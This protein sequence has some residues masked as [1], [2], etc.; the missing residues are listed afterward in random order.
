MIDKSVTVDV[1]KLMHDAAQNPI[2]SYRLRTGMKSRELAERWGTSFATLSRI[3]NGTQ[4]IPDKLL[5][6]ISRDTGAPIA[7]LR[8][9]LVERREELTEMLAEVGVQ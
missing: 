5:P 7:E 2:R 6:V 1:T 3:E 9:D 8:P 4:R